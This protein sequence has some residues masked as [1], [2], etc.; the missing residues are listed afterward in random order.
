MYAGEIVELGGCRL[1]VVKFYNAILWECG[2]TEKVTKGDFIPAIE[3][4]LQ[5][6]APAGLAVSAARHSS[7]TQ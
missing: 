4:T 2:S 5:A 6:P 1:H 3:A 7:K